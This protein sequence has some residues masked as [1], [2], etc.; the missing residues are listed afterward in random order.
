M[1]DKDFSYLKGFLKINTKK[2]TCQVYQTLCECTNIM[3]R[4]VYKIVANFKVLI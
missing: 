4:G 2:V 3:M 1:S